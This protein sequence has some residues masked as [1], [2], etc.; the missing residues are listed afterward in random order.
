[1][2]GWLIGL[3]RRH[4]YVAQDFDAE[5]CD[6][7]DYAFGEPDPATG[8][9]RRFSYACLRSEPIRSAGEQPELALG[10]ELCRCTEL[11]FN[12]A[13]GGRDGLVAGVHELVAEVINESPVDYRKDLRRHVVLVGG[14][15]CL[16][17][18]KSHR[19]QQAAD[20]WLMVSLGAGFKE[21]LES[22]LRRALD[23]DDARVLAGA[24]RK[25]Q[26][27]AAAAECAEAGLV[28]L[29]SREQWNELGA[30]VLQLYDDA[31]T[32]TSEGEEDGEESE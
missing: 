7:T 11:L 17:G 10:M 16:R 2:Y 4:A 14:N 13:L 30:E 29:S 28:R 18:A 20:D 6:D 9:S 5:E 3:I 24:S 19:A 22:E 23:C 12:P 25:Y 21:R 27:W 26:A 1:M 15:T 32:E 31:G 8:A